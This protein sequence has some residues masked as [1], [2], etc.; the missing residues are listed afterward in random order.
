MWPAKSAA[1][2]VGDVAAGVGVEG[3]GPVLAGDFVAPFELHPQITSR[4]AMLSVPASRL[5]RRC[6]TMRRAV[7][8]GEYM[9]VSV[10]V[11]KDE[12][13]DASTTVNHVVRFRGRGDKRV[14]L[15]R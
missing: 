10:R 5:L 2:A 13:Q 12:T 14:A 3:L 6:N 7:L 8:R 1:D 9:Q 4:A 11:A 15:R